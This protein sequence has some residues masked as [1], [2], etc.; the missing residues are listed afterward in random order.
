MFADHFSPL[1]AQ[2]FSA[3]DRLQN[4]PGFAA[5]LFCDLLES[6][7]KKRGITVDNVQ[8]VGPLHR[9]RT[10]IG[11]TGKYLGC[12]VDH[13]N[14]TQ[15]MFGD[16]EAV[17]EM[18]DLVNRVFRQAEEAQAAAASQAHD[19]NTEP[20]DNISESTED[21]LEKKKI[22]SLTNKAKKPK[23][24]KKLSF[25]PKSSLPAGKHNEYQSYL[26][27]LSQGARPSSKKQ[28]KID[29]DALL[30]SRAEGLYAKGLVSSIDND[31]EEIEMPKADDLIFKAQLRPVE[32][33]L[34][35]FRTSQY[36]IQERQKLQTQRI[37]NK[38]IQEGRA[39]NARLGREIK[40][41]W[42][43]VAKTVKVKEQ[44]ARAHQKTQLELRQEETRRRNE[45]TRLQN[46]A[47]L[48]LLHDLQREIKEGLNRHMRIANSRLREGEDAYYDTL[49]CQP[50][51]RPLFVKPDAYL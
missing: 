17:K 50:H 46:K 33:L 6:F 10:L 18:I 37:K 24:K 11:L 16:K 14:C 35:E 5:R 34:R 7:F 32:K 36:R 41:A 22:S 25:R 2:Q 1:Y 29:L 42:K 51:T 15:V 39:E 20:S 30:K 13:I 28:A 31:V 27:K 47:E 45:E 4:T 23:K 19:E 21:D 49:D 12:N 26:N 48:K 8:Y 38:S 3:R 40:Q 9:F 43:E 44:A